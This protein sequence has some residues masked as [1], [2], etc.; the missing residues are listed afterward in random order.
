MLARELKQIKDLGLLAPNFAVV[1]V[2]PQ[3]GENIGMVARAMGN[4]AL[5]DLRLNKVNASIYSQNEGSCKAFVK[6]GWRREAVLRNHYIHDDE[7]MDIVV[8]TKINMIFVKKRYVTK[9]RTKNDKFEIRFR[10][11]DWNIVN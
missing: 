4:C 10:Y 7:P 9:F 3:L 2:E 5:G 11:T 1:L 6:A 8:W